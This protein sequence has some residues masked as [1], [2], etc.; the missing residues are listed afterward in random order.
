M[1]HHNIRTMQ[2]ALQHLDSLGYTPKTIA[3]IRPRIKDCAEVYNTPLDRIPTDLG[4]FEARWGRGRIGAIPAGFRSEAHFLEFRKRVGGMLARIHLPAQQAELLPDWDELVAFLIANGG[5]GRLLGPHREIGVAFVGEHAS[6]DGLSPAGLDTAW[7]DRAGGTLAPGDRRRFKAGVGTVICLQERRTEFPEIAHLLPEAPLRQPVRVVAVPSRWRRAGEEDAAEL[8]AGFDRFVR[9]KRGTDALG[10][11]VPAEN[12][13]FSARTAR[14]YENAL[15]QATGLLARAGH[16]QLGDRPRL[17]DICHPRMLRVLVELWQ[18]RMIDGEVR[19]DA[20]TLHTMIARL[21]HIAAVALDLDKKEKKEIKKI[22]D[23]VAKQAKHRN[24]MSAPRLAWIKEFARSPAQ[25]R[26]LHLMPETLMRQAQRILDD[27]PRLT[28]LKR[29]KQRMRAL[30]LGIAATQAAILFRGSALRAANLNGLRFRGP[31]AELLFGRRAGDIRIS[32]P[33]NLVKNRAEIAAEADPDAWQ[34]IDWYLREIRPRLITDHPYGHD[35][36]DSD[37]LFPSKRDDLP[38]DS[39]TFAGHYRCGVRAAGLD[40]TL[41]QARHVSAYLILSVDP[42]ALKSA[43]A[44][45]AISVGMVEAHYAW[46]DGVK[47]V[48]QGRTLMLE[49]RKAARA[50]RK[51]SF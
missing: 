26:A 43:A 12:S 18:T 27:W 38:M 1:S 24:R 28:R 37:F 34:I 45:L 30:K 13:E 50:H 32:I 47:A 25:Q 5:V 7:I 40:M 36:V 14:N 41:H 51:G 6:R 8:W 33:G 49:A 21:A 22:R 15:T 39:T 19:D 31:E 11:P 42:S 35:L 20:S 48:A 46:I 29:H 17:E 10:R 9:Q 16:L 44:V 3:Q 2:D 23:R 4:A